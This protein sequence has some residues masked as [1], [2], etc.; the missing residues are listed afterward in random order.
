MHNNL[1]KE[2][3]I[4]YKEIEKIVE[5]EENQMYI[6]EKFL[7]FVEN[8]INTVVKELDDREA[9]LE[10]LSKKSDLIESNM[11]ELRDRVN[12]IASDIYEDNEEG[13]FEIIC[14]Y[15]NFEFE[16]DIGEDISEI[17]CPECENIIELDWDGNGSDE[18]DNGGCCGGGCSRCKGCE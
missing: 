17:R 4:F 14:P 11:Q 5:G 3:E 13:D 12:Y 2:I 9:R 7:T 1:K 8:A 6:K 15:C 18:D 10:E 16:A